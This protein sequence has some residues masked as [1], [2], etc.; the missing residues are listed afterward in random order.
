[1]LV[2]ILALYTIDTFVLC[3]GCV[4]L[5]QILAG[6]HR[7]PRSIR[8]VPPISDVLELVWVV[9]L[10]SLAFVGVVAPSFL[11]NMVFQE[12]ANRA[13]VRHQVPLCR[14][15]PL[16]AVLA[17][18]PLSVILSHTAFFLHLLFHQAAVQVGV[19]LD[20]I[21]HLLCAL[22]LFFSFLAIRSC[23]LGRED[24]PINFILQNV[25]DW[26]HFGL[27]DRIKRGRNL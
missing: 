9:Y 6:K 7:L 13:L 17:H 21:E 26:F 8:R 18:D 5:Q 14:G 10:L 23:A 19:V 4:I 1:M 15:C 27:E 24:H 16:D 12:V 2:F 3:Q 22:L 25:V 20:G 11:R